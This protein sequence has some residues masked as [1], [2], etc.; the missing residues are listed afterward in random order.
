MPDHSRVNNRYMRL[1]ATRRAKVCGW[2]LSDEYL[3]GGAPR[4]GAAPRTIETPNVAEKIPVP[5]K[6][7]NAWVS[8][9]SN[10]V[11]VL[12]R[13]KLHLWDIFTRFTRGT[14]LNMML[15]ATS[16]SELSQTMMV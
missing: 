6:M 15:L 1:N 7:E 8:D 13:L 9:L 11:K 12:C 14:Y 5:W 10:L 3:R 4:P 16:L 2:W